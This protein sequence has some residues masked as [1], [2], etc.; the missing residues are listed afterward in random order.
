MAPAL[1]ELA[2][3]YPDASDQVIRQQAIE[4][5]CLAQGNRVDAVL[6]ARLVEARILALL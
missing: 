1:G 3:R 4:V 5:L 6:V 2:A